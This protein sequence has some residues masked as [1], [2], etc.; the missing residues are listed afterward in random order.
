MFRWL[1]VN[2]SSPLDSRCCIGEAFPNFTMEVG[3]V[4]EVITTLSINNLAAFL[5]AGTKPLAMIYDSRSF[6]TSWAAFYI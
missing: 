5:Y 2:Y 1:N 4:Q 6:H 3:I